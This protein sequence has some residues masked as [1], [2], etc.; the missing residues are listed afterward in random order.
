MEFRSPYYLAPHRITDASGME[1]GLEEPS[2]RD[3]GRAAEHRDELL[4]LLEVVSP[5]A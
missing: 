4:P 3:I 5:P 2:H 1:C